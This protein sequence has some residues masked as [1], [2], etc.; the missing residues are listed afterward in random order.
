VRWLIALILTLLTTA[1][2]WV[3]MVHVGFAYGVMEARL[4]WPAT[5]LLCAGLGLFFRYERSPPGRVAFAFPFVGPLAW[6]FVASAVRMHLTRG[7]VTLAAM[8]APCLW[9]TYTGCLRALPRDVTV[10]L[11]RLRLRTLLLLVALAAGLLGV[12]R[13]VLSSSIAY[14]PRGRASSGR[15]SNWSDIPS[16]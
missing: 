16:G 13:S 10:R 3:V 14:G 4:I 15:R 2:S 11:P 8:L 7:F 12:G 5:L 9:A 1:L 6:L